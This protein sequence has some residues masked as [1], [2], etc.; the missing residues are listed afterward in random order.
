MSSK[1]VEEEIL[2]Q[3]WGSQGNAVGRLSDGRTVFVRGVIPGEKV[4]VR[5]PRTDKS[6]TDGR[7]LAVI[8]S[9]PE[10]IR[11][12][13]PY[14]GPCALCHYQFLP[15]EAQIN[16]KRSI[17]LEQLT[18]IG[19]LNQPENCFKPFI[20]SPNA[21]AYRKKMHFSVLPDGRLGLPSMHGKQTIP[22]SR[23]PVC[24]DTINQMIGKVVFEEG[25]GV[26]F[27]DIREGK[28]EEIQLILR[29]DSPK[30]ETEIETDLPVSLVYSS[31]EGSYV[32]AGDST[33][34]QSMA[35]LDIFSSEDSF[36]YPN[37]DIYSEVCSVL[38]DSL[39]NIADETV[40]N[41]NAGTGF[42]SKWFASS[43][44]KVIAQEIDERLAEDFTLNLDAF[45]NVE[46]YIGAVNEVI[47]ALKDKISI[48][49]IESAA[50]G[51]SP[52]TI[53]ALTAKKVGRI[54]YVGHDSALLARDAARL[55]ASGYQLD[56]LIPFDNE[57][58]TARIS[59]VAVYRLQS[60][61]AQGEY[62]GKTS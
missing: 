21:F 34:P 2:I 25:S 33:I 11:P 29:G 50:G 49:V 9:S 18:R 23:C 45:D 55:A 41:L 7:L 60:A 53:E 27:L 47:P 38:A 59:A 42:W 46:L 5:C 12:E 8:S 24:S 30:P 32:M 28:E 31:P 56:V 48:A 14:F 51:L 22:V 35:A 61:P 39:G 54:I 13:C 10:R 44:R 36:F 58:Q 4:R 6:F 17:L 26:E 3:S 15:I 1:H 57:P 52:N 19:G 62:H 37:P 43:C 40:F 16:A 20:G